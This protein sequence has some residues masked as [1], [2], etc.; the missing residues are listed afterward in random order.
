MPVT[1]PWCTSCCHHGNEKTD[2]DEHQQLHQPAT[3]IPAKTT[4]SFRWWHMINIANVYNNFCTVEVTA[5]FQHLPHLFSRFAW[6][7]QWYM[8]SW[9]SNLDL[10][11]Q[12]RSS[13]DFLFVLR[14]ETLQ[15]VEKRQWKR[16]PLCVQLC[17][18]HFAYSLC[19]KGTHT[20]TTLDENRVNF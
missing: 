5:T 19:T 10:I 20:R 11:C 9:Q 12:S 4:H 8:Y 16:N 1:W 2:N 7:L 15:S 18:N 3:H 17:F 14:K 6:L 13:H